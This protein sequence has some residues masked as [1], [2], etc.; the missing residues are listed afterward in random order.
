VD[1]RTVL[2]TTTVIRATAAIAFATVFA[3]GAMGDW[4]EPN[5]EWLIPLSVFGVGAAIGRWWAVGLALL[6]VVLALPEGAGGDPPAVPAAI[7]VAV[8]GACLLGFGVA[9]SKVLGDVL[10]GRS[11]G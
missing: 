5:H 1:E 6:P 9:A 11:R 8:M 10:P 2:S 4:Y 7:Y 3:S